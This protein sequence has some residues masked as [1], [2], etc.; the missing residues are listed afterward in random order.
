MIADHETGARR[1]ER[2][3]PLLIDSS[4]A[5]AKPAIRK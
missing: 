1:L 3:V 2:I 5:T 4:A